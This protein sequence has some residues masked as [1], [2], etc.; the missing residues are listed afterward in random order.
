MATSDQRYR[1]QHEAP[2]EDCDLRGMDDLA[3]ESKGVADRA[4]YIADHAAAQ[5]TRRTQYDT[6][7]AAYTT[8]RAHVAPDVVG[9][10]KDLHQVREQLRCQL[11]HETITCLDEAWEEVA[12]RLK[13]CGEPRTGCCVEECD[14]DE[15]CRGYEDDDIHELTA[16]IA[17]IERRVAA[18]EACFDKLVTEPE[19]LVQR[20]AQLRTAVD[21]LLTEISDPKTVD[22]KHAYATL[23]WLWHRYDGIWWGF[24]RVRDFQ[25]CL[26]QALTCSVTGRRVLGILTGR[27]G[28]LQCRKDAEDERCRSLRAHVVQ[29]ILEICAC[30]CGPREY[31]ESE[32]AEATATVATADEEEP[33]E[34]A[35]E[36]EAEPDA[37]SEGASGRRSSW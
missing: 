3:C 18:A 10:R 21:A 36:E 14:F 15:A 34:E 27:L 19:A 13:H 12:E 26:C 33:E 8:A 35:E 16:R 9:I 22:P 20:V 6:T 28:V 17:R 37:P 4:K 29:E 31:G 2:C 1:D 5:A 7:R 32:R 30:K 25:D 23:R 24:P 11:D